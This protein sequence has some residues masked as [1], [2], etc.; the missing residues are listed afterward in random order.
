MRWQINENDLRSY[1][2][3]GV[4]K[5]YISAIDVVCYGKSRIHHITFVLHTSTF[6]NHTLYRR[7]SM[8]ID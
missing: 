7:E 1:W 6:A 2:D 5:S 3:G 8:N 4:T